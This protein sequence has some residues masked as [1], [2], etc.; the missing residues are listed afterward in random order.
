MNLVDSISEA[1][2]REEGFYTPGT[3]AA[4]NHNPGNLRSW[5]SRPIVDGYAAFPTDAD[6]WQALRVQVTKNINR[7]LT[8]TEFF[9]GK[10]G[11]YAGYSPA[12]DRNRPL[13][14]AQFVA[15]VVGLPLDVPLNLLDGSSPPFPRTAPKT[16]RRATGA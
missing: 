16:P 13:E 6:G 12:A 3:I 7:G 9:V 15:G 1:I 4:R 5:G 10:P 11:V 14:Y 8:L 2:A